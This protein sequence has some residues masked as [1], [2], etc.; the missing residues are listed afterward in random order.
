[1]TLFGYKVDILYPKR[2]PKPL[3]ENLLE[4][5]TKFGVGI[6]DCVPE[7]PKLLSNHYN[8]M[9]DA[10]FGFSFRPPVRTQLQPALNALIESEVP[11]CW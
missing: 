10:L 6:V 8:V 3:Y 4:Q 11:V 5:C 1:M 2:T 7:D 9:V